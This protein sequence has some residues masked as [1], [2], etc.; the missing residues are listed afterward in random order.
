MVTYTKQEHICIIIEKH[1]CNMYILYIIGEGSKN[2]NIE[3]RYS[4]RSI[5]YCRGV[6]KVGIVGFKPD[7]VSDEVEFYPCDD[8]YN[9]KHKN[10]MRKV[11]GFAESE[12]APDHFL[13][14]SDDHIYI[15]PCDFDNYPVYYQREELYKEVPLGK[16]KNGYYKSLVETRG[17]LEKY[18]LPIYMCNI[19]ANT[20]FDTE[21]YKHNR[22]I[23][24]EAMEL[25]HGGEVSAIM[26]NLMIAN[27]ATQTFFPDKKIKEFANSKELSEQIYEAECISLSDK[28]IECGILPY[29]DKLFPNKCRYEK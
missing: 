14:S 11:L 9:R 21:L 16:G 6:D 8:P 12:F 13:M 17:L 4:L 1:L 20:H 28:S 2:D 24:A 29:I 26:G 7:F 18:N 3:L 10:M 27:G 5:S 15:R 25:E 19:H 23:F 22:L